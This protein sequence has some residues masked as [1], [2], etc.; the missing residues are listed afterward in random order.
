MKCYGLSWVDATCLATWLT[1]PKCV[2]GLQAHYRLREIALWKLN[3]Y[4][5]R[6]SADA[7]GLIRTCSVVLYA[8]VAVLRSSMQNTSANTATVSATPITTK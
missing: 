4:E 7:D 2:I 5:K 1:D 3:C 6:P 8:M